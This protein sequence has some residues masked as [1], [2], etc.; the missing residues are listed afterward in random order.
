MF[1]VTCGHCKAIL[2]IPDQYAAQSGKCTKCGAGI[3]VP[4]AQTA[5]FTPSLPKKKRMKQSDKTSLTVVVIIGVVIVLGIG[6]NKDPQAP[7]QKTIGTDSQILEVVESTPA[8]DP[9]ASPDLSDLERRIA[10]EIDMTLKTEGVEYRLHELKY[11]GK[12]LTVVLDLQY[13]PAS[14]EELVKDGELWGSFVTHSKIDGKYIV[15]Q[16]INVRVSL[17]TVFAPNEIIDWGAW[18]KFGGAGEW[19]DGTAVELLK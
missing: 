3:Q 1:Q 9:L 16:D 15:E 6:A 4:P 10:N 17:W 13:R 8:P 5:G 14:Y 19:Q 7:N 18:R 12:Q 11:D 2:D